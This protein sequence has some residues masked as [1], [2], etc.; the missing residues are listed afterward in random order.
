MPMPLSGLATTLSN[1]VAKVQAEIVEVQEQLAAGTKKLNPAENGIVTRLSAQANGYSTVQKNIDSGSAV[2]DVAQTA[3]TSISSIMTQLK[4]LATQAMSAGLQTTDISSLNTTFTQLAA[5]VYSLAIN[6]SVNNNNLLN[7][8]GIIITTGI[9]GTSSSQTSVAG[10]E[11]STDIYAAVAALQLS[12]SITGTTKADT[13]TTIYAGTSETTVTGVAGGVDTA[14][15][16]TVTFADMAIGDTIVLGGYKLTAKEEMTANAVRLAFIA[17][18][19]ST[20]DDTSN[21]EY[22]WDNNGTTA[23]ST[24]YTIGGTTGVAT[25]TAVDDGAG[26]TIVKSGT[27]AGQD[28]VTFADVNEND[29]ITVGG[30]TFTATGSATASQIASAFASIAVGTSYANITS[31]IY[32]TWGGT[33]TSTTG[34]AIGDTVT[35]STASTNLATPTGNSTST[36]NAMNAVQVLTAQLV[37]VST[38][39]STLSAASTGLV[40][41]KSAAVSLQAGLESTVGSI[42]NIDA[43]AMQARLQQLNNQQSIDYYLVSQMNTEAAAILSIFR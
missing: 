3:L 32:G 16:D 10:I 35:F 12:S 2:I 42:Q 15:V 26:S 29:T 28:V 18:E 4:S 19:D 25:F 11:M 1:S 43:T 7:G 24:L 36:T 37:S 38:G 5:Q 41:Q 13:P 6:A 30:L 27:T 22:D 8:D 21:D 23:L 20:A 14:R 33:A 17:Q 40:A 9:D 34:V 39:Q 31:S